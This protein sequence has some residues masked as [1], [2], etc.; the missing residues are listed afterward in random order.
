LPK[1]KVAMYGLTTEGYK[2]AGTIVDK[3]EV[4]IIDETLQM[5]L[6]LNSTFM[7]KN[8][9][10]GEMMGGEPLL[11]FKPLEQ[12]LGGADVVFFTP[13][14]RR[15]VDE[16]LVE[17]NSKLRE[18]AKYLSKGVVLVNTLPTGP[19]GNSEHIMLL[20]KQTGLKT[21]DTMTYA[22]APL[23]PDET[24]PRIVSSTE[25]R[26][27]NHLDAIG[28]APNFQNIFSAELQYTSEVLGSAIGSVTQIELSRRAREAKV[29]L[30]RDDDEFIDQFAK[31]LYDLRAIQAG[32]GSGESI[33]YLAGATLKSL[34]NFVR[35]VV[36][37]AR[38]VLKEKELKASRTRVT[39]LWDLD[40]YEMRNDRLQ[41]AGGIQQRLKDYVTDVDIVGSTRLTAGGEVLDPLKHNVVI[42]CSKYG[43]ESI[44]KSKGRRGVDVTVIRASPSLKRE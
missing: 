22:Y 11:S 32:E 23:M 16:S 31:Y 27:G 38:D 17:A 13:K 24:R 41:M 28:L 40:K 3:A 26:D 9:D 29:S 2:L 42:V 8:P 25:R 36:D 19:G 14:L 35:Y 5:A 30:Q 4:T 39:L 44:K 12:V 33:A 6:E 34:E 7:K 37:E 1:P 43:Y 15:P 18:A 21:G 20:E 10:L